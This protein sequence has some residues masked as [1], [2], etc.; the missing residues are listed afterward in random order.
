MNMDEVIRN[1]PDFFD[2][3]PIF[4]IEYNRDG[5]K[6]SFYTL[7]SERDIKETQIKS[8]EN[9]LD[10]RFNQNLITKEEYK[11]QK[12]ELEDKL[13]NQNLVYDDL[14]FD[15]ISNEEL[16]VIKEEIKNSNLNDIDL[17]RLASSL[18]S[19]AETK[20]DDFQKNNKEFRNDK[21]SYWNY[22]YDKI[23]KGYA[24]TRELEGFILDLIE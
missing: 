9:E 7:A 18:S 16:D 20:I 21:I 4:E 5:T 10:F 24:R 8:D 13:I 22:K 6:K 3:Y 1:N 12:S 19:I 17:K 23:A 14:I 2:E 11:K 15:I